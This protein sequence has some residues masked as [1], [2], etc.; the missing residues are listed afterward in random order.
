MADSDVE[1]RLTPPTGHTTL[2]T[3]TISAVRRSAFIKNPFA[4]AVPI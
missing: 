2:P 4:G 3:E 1:T